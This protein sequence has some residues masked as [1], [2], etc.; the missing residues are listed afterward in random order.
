MDH[1]TRFAQAYPTKNKSGRTTADII[2]NNYCLKYGFPQRLHHDQ[3]REFENH[4]FRRL[5]EHSGIS[6]SRTTPHH[7]QGNG[8]VERFNRTLLGMLRTLAEEQKSDWRASVDKMDMPTI[9][10]GM[11]QLDTHHSTYC[12]A[13]THASP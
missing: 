7:P 10:P 5:Q 1:F 8:Q 4:L 13:G 12:L 11:N 2:F 6:H 9:A 3:G